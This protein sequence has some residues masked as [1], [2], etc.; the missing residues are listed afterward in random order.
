VAKSQ[1]QSKRI[2]EKITAAIKDQILMITLIQ[3]TNNLIK[4][5]YL[6]TIQDKTKNLRKTDNKVKF[7][8]I[9]KTIFL[10]LEDRLEEKW[11]QNPLK[12]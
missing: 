1:I 3:I 7:L 4:T 8:R 2:K 9:K 12:I 10:E 6:E 11:I 5:N